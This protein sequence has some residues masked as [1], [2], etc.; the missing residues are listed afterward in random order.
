MSAH[1]HNS[2]EPI[3]SE[4]LTKLFQPFLSTKSC[5]TGLG[6]AISKGNIPIL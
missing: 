1:V 6:L 4:I 5:G 2:G 3:P